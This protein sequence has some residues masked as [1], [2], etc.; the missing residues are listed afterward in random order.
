MKTFLSS[1]GWVVNMTLTVLDWY[2]LWLDEFSGPE[3]LYAE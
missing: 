2:T 1:Y 3:M